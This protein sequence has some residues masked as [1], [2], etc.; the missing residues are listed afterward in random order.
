MLT[1]CVKHMQH[2]T[3][4]RKGARGSDTLQEVA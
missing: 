3:M 1:G 4:G 2:F